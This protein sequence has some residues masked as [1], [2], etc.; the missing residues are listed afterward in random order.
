VDDGAEID[1]AGAQRRDKGSRS[2]IGGGGE[3]GGGKTKK[4]GGRGSIWR[5][6]RRGEKTVT[7]VGLRHRKMSVTW[8]E[9]KENVF[10][11]GGAE[12][13]KKGKAKQKENLLIIL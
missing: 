6:E 13:N 9:Y 1:V 7:G 12:R 2:C 11:I 4:G 3:G 8:E 5:E 10:R